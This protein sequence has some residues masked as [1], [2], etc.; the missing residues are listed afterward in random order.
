MSTRPTLIRVLAGATAAAIVGAGLTA[1]VLAPWPAGARDPLSLVLSPEASRAVAV[2]DGPLLA[3]GRDQT[4]AGSIA[5]AAPGA[6]VFDGDD[7]ITVGEL[8]TPDRG[9]DGTAPTVVSADPV[10]GARVDL[11]AASASVLDDEDLRGLAVSSCTRPAMESW[12][13]G[14]SGAT[15]A[16]DV[17]LLANPGDVPAQVDLRVF[18]ANGADDPVAGQDLVVA[19]GSQRAVPLAAIARGEETPV[20]RVTADGAAVRAS[21]QTTL[22]RTLIA[23]GVDQVSAA[24][25]PG[26]TQIIPAVDVTV[27]PDAVASAG[28]LTVRMMA[29]GPATTADVV[30]RSIDDGSVVAREDTVDLAADLPVALALTGMPVGRY[31]VSIDADEPVVAAAWTSTDLAAPS[32]FAWATSAD[33]IDAPTLV[34]IADAPAPT[35][36]I[37]AENDATVTVETLDGAAGERIE[38]EAGR[39]VTM[40][41][42]AGEVYRIDPGTATV[43][44]SVGFAAAGQLG[45]YPVSAS[46]AAAAELTIYP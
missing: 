10:A 41:V 6:V 38:I 46:A 4:A 40:P 24:A 13:V 28:G 42:T 8:A 44:A 32:D 2:C 37:V 27:A 9:G 34:A 35:M 23:G 45:V 5:E 21:L 1:A 31:T 19:A 36:T 11:A 17:V 12:L 30:V 7:G 26:P 39:A 20:I 43:R 3:L 15:G 16:S 22:T 29:T 33:A 18:G 14:G 25:T